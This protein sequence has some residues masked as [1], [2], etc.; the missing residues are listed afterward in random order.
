MAFL[1]VRPALKRRPP[2]IGDAE[3]NRLYGRAAGD[4]LALWTRPAIMARSNPRARTSSSS[5]RPC[6]KLASGASA[7]RCSSLRLSSPGDAV[8]RTAVCESLGGDGCVADT[9]LKNRRKCAILCRARRRPD[10]Q[11]KLTML[12]IGLTPIRDPIGD[13]DQSHC[14]DARDPRS[15]R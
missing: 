11:L 14:P 6:G 13:G 12:A 5:V 10:R 2:C 9:G 4:D 1:E 3:A 15:Q 7:W 8:I